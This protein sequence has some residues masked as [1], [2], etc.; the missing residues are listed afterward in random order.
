MLGAARLARVP[1]FST[2][3]AW[4][5]T[6]NT[7]S[8]TV[9]NNGLTAT[10]GAASQRIR[11]TLAKTDKRH[12]EFR[13]GGSGA[14]PISFG[15]SDGATAI[16][17]IAA[18]ANPGLVVTGGLIYLNGASQGGAGGVAASSVWGIEIDGTSMRLFIPAVPAGL[19]IGSTTASFPFAL[20]NASQAITMNPG[21]SAFTY[22]VSPGF[23]AYQA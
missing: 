17:S 5:A 9:T 2:A 20:L 16:G 15:L 7:G 10:G 19:A 13:L 6:D 1:V 4:S 3:I 8:V 18:Q 14:I 12:I 23:S 22:A 21:T 11:A